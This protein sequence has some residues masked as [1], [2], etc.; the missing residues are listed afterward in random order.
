MSTR[1][2][3][4]GGMAAVIAS[5]GLLT[6]LLGMA[7]APGPAAAPGGATSPS[8]AVAPRAEWNTVFLPPGNYTSIVIATTAKDRRWIVSLKT[9]KGVF[10]I[11][12]AA[13][14]TTVIPFASGWRVTANDQARIESRY[15]PFEDLSERTP[16]D[17]NENVA[18]SAWGVTDQ[19]P[20]NFV[21]PKR[22]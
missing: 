3:W 4:A 8:P 12:V 2:G 16:V 19:G 5:A 1:R 13:G 14:E 17:G 18:L 10:P 15:V 7:Q 6:G 9:S 22:K 21:P 20:V 11:T